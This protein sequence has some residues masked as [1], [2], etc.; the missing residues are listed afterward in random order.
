MSNQSD[1]GRPESGGSQQRQGETDHGETDR[2]RRKADGGDDGIGFYEDVDIE[3]IVEEE[4]PA[5]LAGHRDGGSARPPKF[6][7]GNGDR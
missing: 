7:G 3:I 2:D 6:A 5:L 4:E 1:K